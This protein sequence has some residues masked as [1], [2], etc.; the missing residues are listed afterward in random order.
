MS[1]ACLNIFKN[2]S[3]TIFSHSLKIQQH[4]KESDLKNNNKNQRRGKNIVVC[5]TRKKVTCLC[6]SRASC[7]CRV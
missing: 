4:Q 6:S 3:R 7:E 1:S 5:S 2:K